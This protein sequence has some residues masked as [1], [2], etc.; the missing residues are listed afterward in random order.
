M[1]AVDPSYHGAVRSLVSWGHDM[2]AAVLW[3]MMWGW[4]GHDVGTVR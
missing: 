2:G 3:I 4:Q 1:R